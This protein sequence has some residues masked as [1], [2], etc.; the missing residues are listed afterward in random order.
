[1]QRRR[2]HDQGIGALEIGKN[3]D[4]DESDPARTR[5][6]SFLHGIKL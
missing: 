6:M 2:L 4:F 5:F 1:V 3:A